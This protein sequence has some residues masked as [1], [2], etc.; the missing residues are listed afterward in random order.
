MDSSKDFLIFKAPRWLIDFEV[1][2]LVGS[3]NLYHIILVI[4]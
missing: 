4:D 2:K 1:F 3:E